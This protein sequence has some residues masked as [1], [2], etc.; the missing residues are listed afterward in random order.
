[1][2]SAEKVAQIAAKRSRQKEAER[3]AFCLKWRDVDR[4]KECFPYDEV[5]PENAWATFNIPKRD[6]SLS[7]IFR[8]FV[9][10]DIV[11]DLSKKFMDNNPL[12]GVRNYS[13]SQKRTVTDER[14]V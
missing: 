7:N 5:A 12:L 11:A 8:K 1:M 3:T 4:D 6:A 14:G 9:T 10:D 2:T 13:Q